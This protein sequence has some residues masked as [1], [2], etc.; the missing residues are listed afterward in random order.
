MNPNN[1]EPNLE[2]PSSQ[3]ENKE[4][5]FESTN[6]QL[7]TLNN[8]NTNKQE[9][10]NQSDIWGFFK[11]NEKDPKKVNCQ[12]FG[13]KTVLTYHSSTTSLITHL[14]K[15][16]PEVYILM[17]NKVSKVENSQQKLSNEDFK[18]KPLSQ[19]KENL[20]K[21]ALAK[22]HCNRYETFKYIRIGNV[23]RID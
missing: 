16:H 6:E 13:C 4:E 9:R 1:S 18:M 21:T 10:K 23:Q 17:K 22:F 15:I 3:S 7:N 11:K 20:I 19:L 14:E 5:E 12:V 2:Q 8:Q